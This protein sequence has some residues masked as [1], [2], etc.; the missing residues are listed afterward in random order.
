MNRSIHYKQIRT[1]FFFLLT[2]EPFEFFY[3]YY[4]YF[5]AIW[6]FWYG[7]VIKRSIYGARWSIRSSGPDQIGTAWNQV[8]NQGCRRRNLIERSASEEFLRMEGRRNR[9]WPH[10]RAGLLLLARKRINYVSAS[11][12]K[13]KRPIRKLNSRCQVSSMAG[14]E[15]S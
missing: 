1:G 4:Y 6:A 5:L 15:S 7:E 13:A 10:P 9:S 11:L 14:R 3:Y 12:S 8:G 2:K